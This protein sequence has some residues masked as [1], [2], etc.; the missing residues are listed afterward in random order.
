MF[1]GTSNT[2]YNRPG[3]LDRPSGSRGI[4]R[5]KKGSLGALRGSNGVKGDV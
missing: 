2:F 5:G 4:F 1:D 3:D